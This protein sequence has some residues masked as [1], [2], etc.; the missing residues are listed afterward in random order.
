LCQRCPETNRVST[1]PRHDTAL[2]DSG[3]IELTLT[4]DG[5]AQRVGPMRHARV[6]SYGLTASIR[7]RQSTRL[8]VLALDLIADVLGDWD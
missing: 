1:V 7:V 5:H 4:I 3:T 8:D 6:P 2:Y